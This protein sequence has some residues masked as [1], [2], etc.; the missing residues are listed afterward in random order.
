MLDEY[1]RRAARRAY[2]PRYTWQDSLSVE[3]TIN[4]PKLKTVL[5][6]LKTAENGDAASADFRQ[7]IEHVRE[8]LGDENE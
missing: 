3:R 6:V 5:R 4:R 8:M 2:V 7:A 1:Q